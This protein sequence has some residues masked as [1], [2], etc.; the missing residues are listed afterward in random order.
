MSESPIPPRVPYAYSWSDYDDRTV[1]PTIAAFVAEARA[2]GWSPASVGGP[3][4]LTA[5]YADGSTERVGVQEWLV[6]VSVDRE[7]VARYIDDLREKS[8]K[9]DEE[10]F[11]EHKGAVVTGSAPLYLLDRDDLIEREVDARRWQWKEG[12]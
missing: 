4:V 6:E 12:V 2:N 10:W 9:A 1:Y 8:R 11:A 5:H 3:D 7:E